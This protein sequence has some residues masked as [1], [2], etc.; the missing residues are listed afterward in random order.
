M[1]RL[2]LHVL[3]GNYLL[4]LRYLEFQ[5]LLLHLVVLDRIA[6]LI[7]FLRNFCRSLTQCCVILLKPLYLSSVLRHLLEQLLI[8]QLISCGWLTKLGCFWHHLLWLLLE[9]F[10]LLLKCLY[11]SLQLHKL[12]SLLLLDS[13]NL[14]VQSWVALSVLLVFKQLFGLLPLYFCCLQPY[15]FE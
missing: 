13:L 1:L 2:H 3:F 4:Q 5:L 8:L 7:L 6:L 9:L 10:N 14:L 12:L 11:F 15:G